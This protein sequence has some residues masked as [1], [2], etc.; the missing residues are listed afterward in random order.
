MCRNHRGFVQAAAAASRL[1]CDLVPLNSDFAGP[2]LADVLARE[3]VTAAVYDQEFE[4]VFDAAEFGGTRVLAWHE[5]EPARPT[6]QALISVSA[7]RVKAGLT[8]S[9]RI[10]IDVRPAGGH[11]Q[12]ELRHA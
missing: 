1:G 8:P 11:R 6:I 5:G 4:P 3:G 10:V 12:D 9:D 7:A 2:Q